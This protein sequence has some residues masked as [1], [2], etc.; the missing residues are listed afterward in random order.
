M[1]RAY[2]ARHRTGGQLVDQ[3]AVK[4]VLSRYLCYPHLATWL[5][6][7]K[8]ADLAPSKGT[9]LLGYRCDMRTGQGSEVSLS[10]D[11]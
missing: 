8:Q 6:G 2:L 10:I 9:L 11:I 3:Q 1:S 5:I 7:R 4:I